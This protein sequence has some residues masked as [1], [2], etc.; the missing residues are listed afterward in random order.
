MSRIE[1]LFDGFFEQL[2]TQLKTDSYIGK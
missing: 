2:F 1:R